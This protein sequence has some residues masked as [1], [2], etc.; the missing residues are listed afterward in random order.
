MK[1]VLYVQIMGHEYPVEASADEELYVNRLAQFIQ[2][3][4]TELKDESKVID[5]YKLAVLTAMN[6]AD[7]LFRLQETKGSTSKALESKTDDLLKL[8]DDALAA[9]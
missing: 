7:E 3:R 6:I 5:S 4:M 8:L 2:E 1:N 9:K